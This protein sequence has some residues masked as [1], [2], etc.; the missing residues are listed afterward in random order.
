MSED[1]RVWHESLCGCM[2]SFPECF[3][4]ILCPPCTFGYLGYKIREKYES[5]DGNMGCFLGCCCPWCGPTINRTALRDHF[6]LDGSCCGDC[7]LHL[8]CG[9]CSLT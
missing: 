1:D 4:S 2:N 9:P 7:L 8:L 3:C 5:D 6:G